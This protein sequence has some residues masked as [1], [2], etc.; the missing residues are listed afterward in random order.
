M[1]KLNRRGFFKT[2]AGTLAALP[3]LG[4]FNI[5]EAADAKECGDAPA[6]KRVITPGEG[7]AKRLDYVAVASE[8]KNDKYKAGQDC[9][10]CRFYK[11]SK[12]VGDWAPCAMM[13][14]KY[15]SACGWCK[16]YKEKKK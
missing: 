8:S 1:N 3:V 6:D 5:V 15:V 9:S 14:S 13:A 11:E 10:N 7:P 4:T 16:S 12:K 2:L